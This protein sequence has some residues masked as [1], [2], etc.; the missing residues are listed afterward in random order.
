MNRYVEKVV[1]KRKVCHK[2]WRKS[3]EDKYTLDLAKKEV[4]TVVMTAQ[5]SKL[6]EF[7]VDLQSESGRKNCFRIARQMAREG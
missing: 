1:A 4:Y 3:S 2:A 5:E 7:T 6:Q